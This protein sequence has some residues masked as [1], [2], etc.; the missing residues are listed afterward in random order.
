MNVALFAAGNVGLEVSRFFCESNEPLACVVV[1]SKG[2]DAQNRE[3]IRTAGVAPERVYRSDG[4]GNT[5][6]LTELKALSLDLILLAWWPYI[7]KEEVI[8]IP[9]IG[10]L[11]FHPSYLPHNR[12]KHYNFWTLV[13]DSPFGVT[14]HFVDKGVDSGDIA[15]QSRIEKTWEDT[16]ETLYQ[17]A[18]S[19][20]VKLFKEKYSAIKSGNI[21]RRP[22][23]LNQGS[24]HQGAE[25]EA[26]SQIDLEKT[27]QAR[28]L[29]NVLRARTFSPHPAA[30]FL[31]GGEKYE[32][33]VS[34]RR[35][36]P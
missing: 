31:D 29:L 19:E 10:C 1:D 22:Q 4:L 24:F 34:I 13:E 5:Q 28:S 12:G 35:V 20:I 23:D 18:Q 7:L 9:R 30:W 11:N 33:R 2:N 25:L 15:F 27:Y 26:A 17:K 6:C 36:K 14:L 32:V 21:P 16:G 8:Q 3:I